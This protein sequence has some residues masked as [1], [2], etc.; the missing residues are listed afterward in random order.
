MQDLHSKCPTIFPGM[1]KYNNVIYKNSTTLQQKRIQNITHDILKESWRRCHSK[2][3]SAECK[4]PILR[5]KCK[6]LQTTWVVLNIVK[7]SLYV[8]LRKILKLCH[9]VKD[10][11]DIRKGDLRY[12]QLTIQGLVVHTTPKRLVGLP[13]FHKYYIRRVFT[14]IFNYYT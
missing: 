5:A 2:R 8:H 4:H 6:I 7:P 3:H 9:Q 10:T 1:C 14:F 11:L 12:K 13:F